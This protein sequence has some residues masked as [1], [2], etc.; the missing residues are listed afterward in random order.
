MA[1]EAADE[2][3]LAELGYKQEF[4]RAFTPLEVRPFPKIFYDYVLTNKTGVWYRVQ[5]HRVTSFHSV[6]AL[7]PPSPL[8]VDRLIMNLQLCPV[9]RAPKWR[10]ERNGVGREFTLSSSLRSSTRD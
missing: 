6:S 9:L 2:A 1:V 8:C 5:Y 10:P 4:R 3:L 7:I